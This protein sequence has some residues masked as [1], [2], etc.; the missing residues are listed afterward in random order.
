MIE[1]ILGPETF[2]HAYFNLLQLASLV[3]GGVINNGKTWAE[4]GI[5]NDPYLDLNMQGAFTN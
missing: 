5:I 4:L 1:G 2:Y 3:V